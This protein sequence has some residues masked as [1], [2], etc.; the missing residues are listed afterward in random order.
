M[1][2]LKEETC[3]LLKKTIKESFDDFMQKDKDEQIKMFARYV[4]GTACFDRIIEFIQ[5]FNGYDDFK[6]KKDELVSFVLTEANKHMI[7]GL[8]L[9]Y[10][11]EK[12]EKDK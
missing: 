5:S 3:S 12:N 2:K 4:V 6:S 1:E 9:G 7:T 10:T 8:S 11:V